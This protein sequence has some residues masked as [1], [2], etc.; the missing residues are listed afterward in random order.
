[1]SLAR[2]AGLAVIGTV[3]VAPLGAQ[4]PRRPR[5]Q[6]VAA[7]PRAMA[8][9][10]YVTASADSA[11]AVQV[12]AGIRDKMTKLTD[13]EYNVLTQDQMNEALRQ[14]LS[15]AEQPVTETILRNVLRQEIP[16]YLHGPASH[17]GGRRPKATKRRSTV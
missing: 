3:I 12:G 14:Y 7:L 6:Q 15:E 9:N 8:A 2:F 4:V 17:A 10:P 1:M 5:E 11:A 16:E 13:G